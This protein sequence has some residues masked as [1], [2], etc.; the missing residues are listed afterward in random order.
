[1]SEVV[2][3]TLHDR[4]VDNNRLL[5]EAQMATP[6]QKRQSADDKPNLTFRQWIRQQV[7]AEKYWFQKIRLFDDLLTPGWSDPAVEKEP[8]FAVPEDLTGKRVLDIGCAEGYFSFLAERRGAAEVVAIDSFPDSVRRFNIC[9]DALGSKATA[10]LCNVYDL[11]ERTFGTFDVVLFYGVLYHLR[12]PLLALE[13]ILGVC[14]GTM[15]LQTLIHEDPALV[16]HSLAKFYPR[17][18]QSG[19]AEE[20][21][22]EQFFDPTIFWVP[23]RMCV[24][25][26]LDSVGFV[27]IERVTDDPSIPFVVRAK[28]PVIAPGEPPDQMKAPWS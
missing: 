2:S 19:P 12:H 3:Q 22:N 10:Y 11:S 17:G 1:M 4:S 24:V 14:S 25:A 16:G 15:M 9:R 27:D 28:S 26:M 5:M 8:Y 18:H 13:K 20:Q 6:S 23:N 21:D 7:E